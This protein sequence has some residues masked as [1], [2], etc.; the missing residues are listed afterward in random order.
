MAKANISK[1]QGGEGGIPRFKLMPAEGKSKSP[2][3]ARLTHKLPREKWGTDLHPIRVSFYLVRRRIV[4]DR[5]GRRSRLR[6]F[7]N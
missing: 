5:P 4:V 1:I 2:L 7:R 6:R 3:L